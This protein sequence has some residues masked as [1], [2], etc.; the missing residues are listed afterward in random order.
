[1]KV[2]HI[3]GNRN[4]IANPGEIETTQPV[5]GYDAYWFGD[6]R[7]VLTDDQKELVKNELAKRARTKKAGS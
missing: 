5:P 6:E 3:S 4:M 2:K 7:V 1:M